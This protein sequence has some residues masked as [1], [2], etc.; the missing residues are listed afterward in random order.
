MAKRKS[1]SHGQ[2]K[3]KAPAAFTPDK[4]SSV[5]RTHKDTLFRFI[6]RDKQKLLQLYN[7]LSNSQYENTD[8]LTVTTLENVVYLSYKNDV[9]F[10]IDMTLY[11]V[12]HQGSW[13]PNMQLR[14]FFYFAR[15]YREYVEVNGYDLYRSGAFTIPYPQF[16]IF[17][18]GRDKKPERQILKL[19]DSFPQR[20][21]FLCFWKIMM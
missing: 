11:L 15:L 1:K 8:L 21:L 13:N 18:N 20:R 10:L 19:S 12:E 6:F 7:A 16:I 14:G 4:H 17:Y 3:K 9:S 2:S 5:Q